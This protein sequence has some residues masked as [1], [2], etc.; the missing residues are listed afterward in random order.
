MRYRTFVLYV[1]QYQNVGDSH[2]VGTR[3]YSVN[4][5]F[6]SLIVDAHRL[7][8]TDQ[9]AMIAKDMDYQLLAGAGFVSQE[10]TW[11]MLEIPEPVL[12]SE[13]RSSPSALLRAAG[14]PEVEEN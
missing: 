3:V 11:Q 1:D 5:Q 2:T 13:P 4:R 9:I 6:T 8:F 12:D 7:G 14:L 10:R